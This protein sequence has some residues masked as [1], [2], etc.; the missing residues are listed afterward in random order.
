[1][2]WFGAGCC[3]PNECVYFTDSFN[4]ADSD[5]IGSDWEEVSGN[6]RIASNRLEADTGSLALARCTK[7]HPQS[8]ESMCAHMDI[9]TADGVYRLIV[10]Y[11]DEDNYCYVRFDFDALRIEIWQRIDG[12]EG[13]LAGLEALT[14]TDDPPVECTLQFTRT[15]LIAFAGNTDLE[16]WVCA[17]YIAGGYWGGIA[18]EDVAGVTGLVDNFQLHQHDRTWSKGHATDCCFGACSCIAGFDER[19][20]PIWKC[21]E[22]TLTLSFSV[23]GD[24]V[25]SALDGA[26]FDLVNTA[27]H[28]L[29]DMIWSGSDTIC[30]ED[31]SYELTCKGT[32]ER[33][34]DLSLWELLDTGV[35]NYCSHGLLTPQTPDNYVC[36]P[37][38][39]SFGPFTVVNADPPLPGSYCQCLPVPG[40]GTFTIEI[41]ES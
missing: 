10:N 13:I 2:P 7:R 27:L 35:D 15:K 22:R 23:T 24:F 16:V 40:S 29:S 39:L 34:Q 11:L 31:F 25:G 1:M 8:D 12:V 37:F 36:D 26:E 30:S 20:F 41:T 9:V 32:G 6:F 28:I 19:G 21:I 3:K 18:V 4:R 5:D 38:Y 14:L 17:D 33:G